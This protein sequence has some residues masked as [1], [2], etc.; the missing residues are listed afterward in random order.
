MHCI[1]YK[2]F[3]RHCFAKLRALVEKV[4]FARK[5]LGVHL[6]SHVRYGLQVFEDL[7]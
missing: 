6:A 1:E 3:L 7:W 2:Y 4:S 5:R